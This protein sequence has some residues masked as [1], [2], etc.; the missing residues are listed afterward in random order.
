MG[1][2]KLVVFDDGVGFE[3]VPDKEIPHR[4]KEDKLKLGLQGLRERVELLG[5][6]FAIRTAHG[7]GTKIEVTLKG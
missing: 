5:G 3:Y 2:I 7:R 6:T 1:N 4:R